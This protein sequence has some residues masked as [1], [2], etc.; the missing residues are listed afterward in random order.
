M[1]IKKAQRKVSEYLLDK[2]SS[3]LMPV[4]DE[5]IFE[6]HPSELFIVPEIKRIMEDF[7]TRIPCTV[8][9]EYSLTNW[10][11]KKD[12]EGELSDADRQIL[13]GN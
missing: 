2:K 4:H 5:L 6:V 8:G 13:S 3:L 9:I 12:W 10:A 7:N 11:D 1:M